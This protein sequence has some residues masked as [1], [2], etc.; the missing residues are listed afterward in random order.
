MLPEP[1]KRGASAKPSRRL[2]TQ[3]HRRKKGKPIPPLEAEWDEVDATGPPNLRT[4]P[5]HMRRS[6]H[7]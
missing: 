4:P 2:D 5:S 3:I 6:E 1:T 7:G